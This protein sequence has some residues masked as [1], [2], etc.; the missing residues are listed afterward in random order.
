[1]YEDENLDGKE[2]IGRW[3]SRLSLHSDTGVLG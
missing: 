3:H 2:E 1:M